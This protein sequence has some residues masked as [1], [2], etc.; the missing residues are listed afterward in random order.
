MAKQRLFPIQLDVTGSLTNQVLTSDGANAYWANSTGSFDSSNLVTGLTGANT[1]ITNLTTGLTGSN[2]AITNLTTGLTGAN[3]AITNLTTG[4]SGS[5]TNIAN[6]TAN[7]VTFQSDVTIQ[8]NVYLRGNALTFTSNTISFG[9]SLL[10][11]AANNTIN[12]VIDIGLYGHYNTGSANSHTG[13]F[14][15][16]VSKDWMLFTGYTIDLDGNTTINIAAPSF[17]YANLRLNSAN[18]LSVYSN[19]VELRA[20]DYATLLE[21]KSNDYSTYTTLNTRINT[22]QSNIS[23]SGAITVV[24]EGNTLTTA[25]TSITFTGAG[26]TGSNVGN[27]VTITI[28]GG[29]SSDTSNISMLIG[30]VANIQVGLSGANTNIVMLTG[31]IA[32]LQA[33]L[34]GANSAGGGVNQNAAYSWTNVHS[35]SNTITINAVSANG[36]LGTAGQILSSTGSDTQWID[37]AAGGGGSFSN[38]QAI[39][40]SN[41][42]Y[43]VATVYK[44]YTYYNNTTFSLDTIFV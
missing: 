7:P 11:L 22:V 37:A 10:S 43:S 36:S 42:I 5:N 20:N 26:V 38:N 2:T 13:L 21:A 6:I 16:A 34:A 28:P 27:A 18:A 3:T 33:G 12:D 24:D 9:D 17:G 1:N 35:F 29:G 23:A 30:N 14:R 4:L 19:G 44:T 39:A 40:V 41:L 15:S 25:L 31:N 32:N 8:G